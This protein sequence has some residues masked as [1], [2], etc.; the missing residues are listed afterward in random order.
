MA[1]LSFKIYTVTIKIQ[2]VDCVHC[3]EVQSHNVPVIYP[4]A[5][6]IKGK[7]AR[8]NPDMPRLSGPLALG[9]RCTQSSQDQQQSGHGN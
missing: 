9:Q 7:L 6:R 2:P 4:D 1:R 3:L 5:T 8:F